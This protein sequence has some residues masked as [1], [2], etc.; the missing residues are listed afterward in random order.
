MGATSTRT[1]KANVNQLG[2]VLSELARLRRDPAN[3]ADFAR[4]E[5]ALLAALTKH[6]LICSAL[7]CATDQSR[8]NRKGARRRA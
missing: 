3:A 5:S 2:A 8:N 6:Q 1:V 7:C 4:H